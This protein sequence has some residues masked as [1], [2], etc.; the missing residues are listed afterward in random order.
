MPVLASRSTSCSRSSSS[1]GPPTCTSRREAPP[2]SGQRQDRASPGV[3]PADARAHAEAPLRGLDD[4]A[5][6]GARGAQEHRPLLCASRARALPRQRLLPA[7][8]PRGGLPPDP[9]AH[10]DARAELGLPA[11]RSTSS[12]ER[13]RG[14][15]LV[16]GPTGS[17]KSTTLAAM[18]DRDQRDAR[19]HIITIEDPIEFLH[20]HK[21]LHR[22][23]ARDRARRTGLRRGAPRRA[24]RGPRRDP[25]RRDARP[26]D[27]RD[28]PDRRRDRPPRLRHA[29]HTGR[30]VGRRPPDRRLPGRPAGADPRPG[31]R[32]AAGRRHAERSSRPSTARD[33]CRRSRFSSPTT[34]SGT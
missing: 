4:R 9:A 10:Q 22:Q 31:R 19:D 5:A 27:D 15:V 23:P 21:Q 34:R 25:P 28:R 13:P 12:R 17:G 3:R 14:L 16:T 30:A 1:S 24:A 29:A 11:R 26:R 8:E 7:R 20:Q 2:R 32:N 18:I 6:E 33:G